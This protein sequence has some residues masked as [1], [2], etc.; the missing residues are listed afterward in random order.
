MWARIVQIWFEANVSP[1]TRPVVYVSLAVFALAT[2]HGSIWVF[3]SITG[4]IKRDIQERDATREN[5]ERIMKTSL[6]NAEKIDKIFEQNRVQNGNVARLHGEFLSH[7][8]DK[9]IHHPASTIISREAYLS[10]HAI[11]VDGQKEVIAAITGVHKRIDTLYETQ[12][13]AGK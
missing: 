1:N 5:V 13:K 9:D 12:S 2:Y 10:N 11:L 6:T 4:R 3:K 8:G 7:C